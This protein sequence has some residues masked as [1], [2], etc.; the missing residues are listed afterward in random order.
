MSLTTTLMIK[1]LLI[2][3]LITKE[4]IK[5]LISND[6]YLYSMDFLFFVVKFVKIEIIIF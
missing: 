4:A 3:E 2:K 5:I 6:Y 1:K